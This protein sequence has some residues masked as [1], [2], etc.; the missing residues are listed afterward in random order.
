MKRA[1]LAAAMMIAAFAMT[2]DPAPA[3]TL[4]GDALRKAV[5]GKTVYLRTQGIELPIV[6]NSNG[7]MRGRLKAFVAAFAGDQATKDT[8]KW[9]VKNDQLCQR[10]QSWMDSK[11]Y[12]YKL[13]RDGSQVQWRRNDGRT[14]TAR[15]GG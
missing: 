8:G 5:I 3:E 14:G 11:T 12:C 4:S 15:L 1:T 7:T 13:K 2:A 6:Y 10:W 9:W